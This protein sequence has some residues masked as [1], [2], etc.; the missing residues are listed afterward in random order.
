MLTARLNGGGPEG[1]AEASGGGA[2]GAGPRD[3]RNGRRCPKLGDAVLKSWNLNELSLSPGYAV[4]GNRLPTSVAP[5]DSVWFTAATTTR[6]GNDHGILVNLDPVSNLVRTWDVDTRLGFATGLGANFLD[7]DAGAVW[8][9]SAT[10]VV[11][12]VDPVARGQWTWTLPVNPLNS[13]LRGIRVTPDDTLM[14]SLQNTSGPGSILQLDAT[15]DTLTTYA[16]PAESTP[17][18][19]DVTRDGLFFF[20]EFSTNRI[21]RLDPRTGELTEW[22]M[23]DGGNPVQLFVA[24][25]G[26]VWFV[27]QQ[28]VGH[29]DPARGAVAFHA[30]EGVLPQALARVPRDRR[31]PLVALADGEPFIDVLCARRVPGQS[32]PS[33]Q[34]SLP[35]TAIPITP[36]PS[37]PNLASAELEPEV[38]TVSPVDPAAFARYA[39]ETPT[40]AVAEHRGPLYATGA[41]LLQS[42]FRFY[43]LSICTLGS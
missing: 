9:S 8:V 7:Q 27:D 26:T 38:T 11:H 15:A 1:A 18:G 37:R 24:P 28:R 39:T 20:C 13:V 36:A 32:V 31:P 43:Q 12:R 4:Q 17:F 6:V 2:R 42:I 30:K 16:L 22:G 5:A 34:T 29:L 33:T 25:D 35:A 19:G 14:I 23:P 10:A 21:A 40:L 41:D 3:E